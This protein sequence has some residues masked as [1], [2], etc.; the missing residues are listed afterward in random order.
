MKIEQPAEMR[1]ELTWE[2]AIPQFSI[3]HQALLEGIQF[4]ESN[5]K[6]LYILGGF[7]SGL[8]V[9]DCVAGAKKAHGRIVKDYS[10]QSYLASKDAEYKK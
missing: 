6:N 10:M 5:I 4:F 2:N 9:S 8:S 7:R 3:G 1:H